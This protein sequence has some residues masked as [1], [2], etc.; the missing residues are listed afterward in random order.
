MHVHGAI[1]ALEILY[2]QLTMII[3]EGLHQKAAAIVYFI[4]ILI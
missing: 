1:D 4:M 3:R 2:R